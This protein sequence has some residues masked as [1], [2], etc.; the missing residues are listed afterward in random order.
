MTRSCKLPVN[1]GARKM[2]DLLRFIFY[3]SEFDNAVVRLV[4]G[5]FF[6]L[7]LHKTNC[8]FL[9]FFVGNNGKLN[10]IKIKKK[11][12]KNVTIA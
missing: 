1:C 2:H 6:A 5:F 8:F 9:C 11:R 3:S 7:R 12:S 4:A 10:E